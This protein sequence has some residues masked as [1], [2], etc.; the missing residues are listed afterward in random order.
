[1]PGATLAVALPDG[2]VIAFAT[3]WAD[4][5]RREPMTTSARLL[6]GSVGKIG[7]A[8]VAM[9]LAGAGSLG[10]DDPVSRWLRT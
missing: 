6:A 1:L 7:V 8:A 9:Q 2:R 5:L 10:P 3:G 4:T